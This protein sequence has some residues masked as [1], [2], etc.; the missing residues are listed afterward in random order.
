MGKKQR[1]LS[2]E[3]FVRVTISHAHLAF[4][5]GDGDEVN[6]ASLAGVDFEPALPTPL[7]R[8]PSLLGWRHL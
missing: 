1:G 7:W 5:M 3:R 2:G 4:G 6:G 8:L